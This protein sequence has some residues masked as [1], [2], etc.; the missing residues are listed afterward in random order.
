MNKRVG[1]FLLNYIWDILLRAREQGFSDTDIFFCQAEECSPWYEQSFSSLNE[2]QVTDPHI[3]INTLYRFSSI[4]QELLHEQT[5]PELRKHLLDIAVHILADRELLSGLSSQDFYV[6][7]LMLEMR[8]GTLGVG[9]AR[10][11]AAFNL[12]E[13][14]KLASLL[15][16][17]YQVGSALSIFQKAVTQFYPDCLIYQVK[18]EPEVI[19][20]YLG[21]PASEEPKIHAL[22]ELFL[23]IQYQ[24]RVFWE[25][26]FG[27]IGVD[28]TMCIDNIEIY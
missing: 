10:M 15:L 4:F 13:Q 2:T 6:Q 25:S 16:L 7:K 23:P 24:L 8:T 18:N 26:H 21:L 17:Q 9:F 14:R 19:L 11:C 27:V 5:R 12:D 20:L 22:Q 28:A 1:E 3:E